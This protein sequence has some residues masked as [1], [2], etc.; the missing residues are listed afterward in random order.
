MNPAKWQNIKNLMSA[1]LDVAAENRAAFLASEPDADV[2]REVEK[3]LAA[4]EKVGAFIDKPILCGETDAENALLENLVGKEI[5][6]Y[7]ILEKTGEGGMGAVFLAEHRGDSFS[8]RVALK[9]IKRGMDTNFVIKRFLMERQILAQLEHPYIARLLDGGATA[10]GLPYL[11]ME[12]VEGESIKKYCEHHQLTTREIL[13]LFTKVCQAVSYAHQKLVIHRDLKPSNIIVTE[14]GEPKLLDFGIAKLF[15]PDWNATAT[16][17]TLTNLR[18]MTP[19]YASPEQLRGRMTTT[20]SD[21]YSL[22]VVLYELLTG[23]R[24]FEFDTNDAFEFSEKILTAEPARPSALVSVA[25]R[26]SAV[27]GKKTNYNKRRTTNDEQTVNRKSNIANRKSLKGD[28]DNIVLKAIRGAPEERYASVEEFCQDIRFYLRGLPVRATKDSRRYRFAKFVRRNRRAVSVAS[29]VSLFIFALSGLAVFQGLT[30]MRERD[31]AN[32]R[33]EKLRDV[34][35]LLMTETR[36]SLHKVPGTM[37]VQKNLAEK[38]VE[39]LDGI[40]DETTTDTQFLTELA[41][42]YE[43][44]CRTQFFNYREFEKAEISCRKGVEIRRRVI[45]LEP[46]NRQRKLEL[47]G[48]LATLSELSF[49]R[50]ARAQVLEQLSEI[51][52]IYREAVEQESSEKNLAR[53]AF[54]LLGAVHTFEVW[55]MTAEAEARRKEG[56]EIL[57]KLIET[58]ENRALTPAE[59]T[60]LAWKLLWQG[61]VFRQLGDDERALKIFERAAEIA[62]NAYRAD[63]SQQFAFNHASR[64][65]REMGEIYEKQGRFDKAFEMYKFSFDW[66]KT[67]ETDAMMSKT[68]LIFGV[69]FYA[70]RCAL[71]LNRLGRRKE[72][73]EIIAQPFKDYSAF[74]DFEADG[75][76]LGYAREPF[77]DLTRYYAETKRLENAAEILERHS[78]RLQKFLDRNADDIGFMTYQ[79]ETEALLGDVFSGYDS[80]LDAFKTNAAERLKKAAG[81]YEK[82]VAI[83]QKAQTLYTPTQTEKIALQAIERKIETLKSRF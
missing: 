74:L 24:P 26:W 31:K 13:E 73:D 39:L 19:E 80:T 53:L 37:Q 3:L 40:Y 22:G 32:L 79:A 16:E 6:D 18:M 12:Y 7:L 59:Q 1:A 9:L 54:Q 64:A 8:Q 29:F 83:Y 50:G 28:L 47:A 49:S 60:E 63:K 2:R 71:M 35:R 78:A 25:E 55:E 72:A 61:G 70:N 15:T 77:L 14:A 75:A 51:E 36:E 20:G 34:A 17:A 44:L 76:N 67:R 10:D 23:T 30:A 4:N 38:S 58:D 69:H 65:H 66:L 43:N 27:N 21:V 45:N 46:E 33:Y 57:Q 42:S 41:A 56:G 68:N 11:V 5:D 48:S 62:Q 81:H 52:L 82:A